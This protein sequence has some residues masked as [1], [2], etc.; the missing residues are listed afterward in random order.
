MVEAHREDVDTNAKATT[1][2]N[3]T[4][5]MQHAPSDRPIGEQNKYK[6]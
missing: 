6:R 4:P 2:I 3:A 1:V 5:S